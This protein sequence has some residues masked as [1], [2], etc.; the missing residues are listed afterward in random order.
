[1]SSKAYFNSLAGIFI[2]LFLICVSGCSK[3]RKEASSS[4]DTT[5]TTPEKFVKTDVMFWLTKSDSTIRFKRQNVALNFA[6]SGTVTNSIVLDSTQTYQTIDGFG[7]AL[8]GG[9]AYLINRLPATDRNNILHELFASD[10]T[11]I[12][13]SYLR[14]SIGSSD[15]NS[16]VFSYDNI[17]ANLTDTAL[18]NFD[19]SPDTYDLIPLLQSIVAINPNIKILGSPWS[20]P[21]WMKTNKSSVGGSL[22]PE[23]Y[24]VYAN[25]FVKYLQAMKANGITLDAITVQNEPE[26]GGNNP[27]M[28]MSAAEEADFVKNNLG[29]AFR[30]ANLATKILIFDHNCDHPDYPITVLSDADA[31]QYIDGS[32]FHLYGGDISALSTV[33]NAY[34]D[35]NVYFTEEWVGGSSSNNFAPDLKWHV[36]NLIIGAPLNWSKNVIEWNLASDP[37][38][39]PHTQG[40]CSTCLGALTIGTSISR[41]VSYY[42]IAHAAKFVKSG[43]VRIGSSVVAG[44]PNV[45]YKTPEGRKVLIVLNEGSSTQSFNIKSGD[46]YV[47]SSLDGG[48]VA[49]YVW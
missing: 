22:K 1:M 21:T 17:D 3:N 32:A 27:S 47:T 31:R 16:S 49:T 38:Y 40:G 46:K 42:I 4:T 45:A 29:L 13:I 14:I 2:I 15:L 35:K 18:K 20:A 12:G 23:Y 30:A 5:T 48:S 44:L 36:K 34:P 26:Y 8:T 33:H 10:S 19:M 7:F 25:Y 43:S 24:K 9:S 6:S 11:F 28:V 39:Q 37:H 41:N